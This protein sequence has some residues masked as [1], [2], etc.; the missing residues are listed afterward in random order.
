MLTIPH[1]EKLRQTGYHKFKLSLDYI[2]ISRL[3]WATEQTPKAE[4][5]LHALYYIAQN[6]ELSPVSHRVCPH[7]TQ[8][9]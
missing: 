6:R 4:K 9:T 3:A 7:L 1:L 8:M 5:R 2:M